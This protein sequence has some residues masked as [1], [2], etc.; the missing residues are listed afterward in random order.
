MAQG[1]TLWALSVTQCGRTGNSVCG[2]G[3]GGSVVDVGEVFF[4]GIDL[5]LV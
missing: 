1:G 2:R 4:Q 3:G 5:V